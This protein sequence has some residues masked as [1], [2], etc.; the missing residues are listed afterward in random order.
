MEAMQ[1]IKGRA[2]VFGDNIDTDAI[3]PARYLVTS[4]PARLAR[5]CM[6]DARPGFFELIRTGD[7]IVAGENFGCGSSREHAP[8]CIKAA[9]I[10][11]VVAESFARIFFRNA[12]NIGLTVF[13][14]PGVSKS[15][16]DGDIIEIAPDERKVKN[17]ATGK[18][19]DYEPYP[20]FLREIA[21]SGGL[22]DWVRDKLASEKG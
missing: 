1:T 10:A 5:H 7:I 20:E 3:I 6:E 22:I 13:E 2:W 17:L 15:C 18:Q 21:R 19:F 8:V 4:D 16:K 12:V 14:A 11:C 9:G